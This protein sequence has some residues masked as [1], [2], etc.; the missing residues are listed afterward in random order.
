MY[1]TQKSMSKM[2]EEK[3]NDFCT[4]CIEELT[5]Q[6][7]STINCCDHKFCYDCISIW[8]LKSSNTCPNC[9]ETFNKITKKDFQGNKIEVKIKDKIN[10]D[11]DRHNQILNCFQCNDLIKLECENHLLCS[12]CEEIAMHTICNQEYSPGDDEFVCPA[13]LEV[14]SESQ[15]DSDD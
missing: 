8:A 12:C 7:L 2:S 6:N 5:T 10:E 15:P 1:S 11:N 4:I 9:K 13:C 3:K 14:L